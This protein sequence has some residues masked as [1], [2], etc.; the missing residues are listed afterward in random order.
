MP[1]NTSTTPMNLMAYS[2]ASKAKA[3]TI[4]RPTTPG[5]GTSNMRQATFKL[6][7]MPAGSFTFT[8]FQT[9]SS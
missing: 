7:K 2:G 3:A 6:G 1:L 5:Y 4:R 9:A 8:R